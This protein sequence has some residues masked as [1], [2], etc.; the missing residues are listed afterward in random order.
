MKIINPKKIPEDML[1]IIILS[2]DLRGVFSWAIKSH[3]NGYYSHA[4]IMINKGKVV[5]QGGTY[6]EVPIENYMTERYRLKFWKPDLTLRD[7]LTIQKEVNK[8]L[9]QNWWRKSYD[10]LG[11]LG[12]LFKVRWL[13]NPYKSFCSERVA[14]YLRLVFDCIPKH[15][16]PADLNKL[17]AKM[18]R[19][20]VYGHWISG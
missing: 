9:K 19:M 17:F 2:D 1:P 5:T 7:I 6:K 11:I 14:K 10:Y 3:T 16:A 20:S 12:Q 15:P 4:M 8:D 13:N 18:G